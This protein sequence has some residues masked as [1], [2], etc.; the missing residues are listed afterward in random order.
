MRLSPRYGF[1]YDWVL[2]SVYFVM[3]R[4]DD[5]IVILEDVVERNPAH[6]PGRLLLIAIYGLLDRIPSRSPYL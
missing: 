5:A 3:G 4:Y 6:S 1:V 2:S